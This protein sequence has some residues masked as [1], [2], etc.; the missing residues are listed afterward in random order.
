MSARLPFY[1]MLS[2]ALASAAPIRLH[3]ENPK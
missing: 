3:P 1:V 2:A